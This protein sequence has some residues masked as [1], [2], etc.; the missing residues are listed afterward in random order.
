MTEAT[1]FSSAGSEPA[2]KRSPVRKRPSL[3]VRASHVRSRLLFMF[4]DATLVVASYGLAQV[5]YLR[6]KA[7]GLYWHHFA[8]FLIYV[9]LVTLIANQAFGLYGRMWRHAGAEEARQ[10]ILS[11]SAVLFVL[12]AGYPPARALGIERINLV[13]VSVGCMFATA[14][15][16]LIRFH[17]RLFAWQRGSRR[18]G[19]RVAVVGSR[20]AGAAIVREM[21]RSP[22][23]GLVPVAVFDD[24]N[25]AH[26]LTMAGVPV[27][28]TIEDIPAAASRYTLQQV[29]LVIPNPPPELVERVFDAAEKA[30]L[31]VNILPG[32]SDIARNSGATPSLRQARPLRIED[33]LG[34][35]PVPID[36]DRVRRSLEGRRVLVTGAGGSIGSEICR[37]VAGLEPGLLVMLDHDETHLHDTAAT[38]PVGCQQA[39][40][41][42][43]NRAAVVEAFERFRPEVVFHAAGHK[44]VPVLED[45]PLEAVGT[46]VFGTLN[47]V[48]A[49]VAVGTQRFVQISS[50]KAVRPSSV[51]GATKRIA[52]Q[53][54]LARA[55][56]GASYCTVRFGNVL[57]SRGSVIP[58]FARQIAD[59]G[60]VTVTDDRMTRFFMS[61]EEAVQLVLESSVLSDGGGEIFMLEMGEPVRILDL[62]TR[63]IQLSGYKPDVDI[64][65]TIVGARPGEKLDE[66]LREPDEQVLT[67]HHP[68]INQL[69]P[70]AAS[71]EQ[72]ADDLDRLDR[73]AT[74]RDADAVTGILFTFG[75][76]GTPPSTEELFATGSRDLDVLCAN[77]TVDASGRERWVAGSF[78]APRAVEQ[79]SKAPT[80]Q[81]PA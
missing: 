6:D 45:F 77:R 44:H 42:I 66:E 56:I 62:A 48:E 10:V 22:G 11:A 80:D 55:P 54:I 32:M 21:M 60:P 9:V 35:T 41:D 30:N 39:L 7:P 8:P 14:G 29:F 38:L 43:T 63:M 16:G 2:T 33:L 3:A 12:I 58:T 57:G 65:I 20:D 81:V 37:Q 79:T 17:S 23:A 78:M 59:G 67:T 31:T 64:P 27:V 4:I 68:Y 19:L 76:S 26:G 15:M 74:S 69:L 34:R 18:V 75:S 25:R 70:I 40:V 72:F 50:D 24:D 5:A 53:I 71:P 1:D 52:E 46:N 47:V 36:L 51:M 13:V 49:A 28:G 61:V 73:A